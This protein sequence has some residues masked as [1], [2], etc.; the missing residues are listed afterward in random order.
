VTSSYLW[1]ET[2]LHGHVPTLRHFFNFSPLFSCFF[3]FLSSLIVLQFLKNLS[4]VF[5]NLFNQSEGEDYNGVWN[6]LA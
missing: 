3:L 6:W 2:D 4:E 5:K 1:V